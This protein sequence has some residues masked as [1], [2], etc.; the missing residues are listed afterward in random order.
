MKHH[1]SPDPAR[2]PGAL[3][4]E[5]RSAQARAQLPLEKP[6]SLTALLEQLATRIDTLTD[7]L[8]TLWAVNKDQAQLAVR[9]RIQTS[10]LV[11]VA[12]F[13]G[14]TALVHAVLLVV[15]GTAA[16]MGRLF[17]EAWIGELVTGAA[18]L[19][20][21]GGGLAL[22]LRRSNQA[23]LKKQAAKYEAIHRKQRRGAG[24]RPAPAD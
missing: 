15:R 20:L 14:G 8:R 11:A 13:A 16:G 9:Q 6:Q 19:G 22:G 5:T 4:D 17:G 7:S 12:T 23:Q 24:S 1:G 21:V 18:V 10:L 2:G 3:A